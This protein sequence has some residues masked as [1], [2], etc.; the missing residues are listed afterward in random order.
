MALSVQRQAFIAEYFRHNFN[1][2]EAARQAGYSVKTARQ[3]ASKLLQVPEIRAEINARI[4]D[5]TMSANEVLIRQTEIARMSM[6]DFS[7]VNARGDLELD[8]SRAHGKL[9]LLKS[10]KRTRR[11]IGNMI[12]ETLEIVPM[13]AQRAQEVMMKYHRLLVERVEIDWRHEL[14]QAGLDPDTTVDTLADQFE[15]LIRQSAAKADAGSAGAG[16]SAD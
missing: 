8:F 9:H 7:R 16:E 10:I 6:G 14:E 2:A 11:T 1:G 12:E 3:I 4:A 13:D 5:L 15:Q